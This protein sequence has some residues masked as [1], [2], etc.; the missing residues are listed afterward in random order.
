MMRA[1][2]YRIFVLLILLISPVLFPALLVLL[3]ILDG[4]WSQGG[5]GEM[6]AYAWL[7]F[8]RGHP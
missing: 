4:R 1:T 6:Y 3:R 5:L 8:R 7:Q 2:A